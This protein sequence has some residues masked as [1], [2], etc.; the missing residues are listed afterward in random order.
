MLPIETQNLTVVLQSPDQVRAIIDALPPS[1]KRE[2]S[3]DWLARISSSDAADPWLHGFALVERASGT[4]VGSAAFKGPPDA[5]GVAEIAYSVSE[6]H[7]GKGYATEAARALT[8]FALAT[9]QVRIVRAHTRPASNASTT[10]L[11]RCGFRNVGEV[12]DPEDGLVWRWEKT[13][14]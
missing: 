7:R 2:V 1:E 8:E 12:V 3:P 10:V 13:S 4:T 14:A 5:D 9:A 11:T 6:E